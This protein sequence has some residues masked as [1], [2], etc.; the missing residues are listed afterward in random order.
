MGYSAQVIPDWVR[1]WVTVID[2]VTPNPDKKKKSLVTSDETDLCCPPYTVPSFLVRVVVGS[3]LLIRYST[4]LG[5]VKEVWGGPCRIV[6]GTT[7]RS[8]TTGRSVT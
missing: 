4:S 3:R 7:V 2:V 6:E 1:L 5:V 8:N